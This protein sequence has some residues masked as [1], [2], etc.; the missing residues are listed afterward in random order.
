MWS[1]RW[2]RVILLLAIAG[3]VIYAGVNVTRRVGE[4]KKQLELL[5]EGQDEDSI[6]AGGGKSATS[7]LPSFKG[8][9]FTE[10]DEEGG[11]FTLSA[12][13]FQIRNKKIRFFRTAMFKEAVMENARVDFFRDNE[14]V[15]SISSRW[16]ILD[17][18]RMSASFTGSVSVRVGD[19]K[20]LECEKLVWS[21]KAGTIKVTGAFVYR[22]KGKV[23]RGAGLYSDIFMSKV[24]IIRR[25]EEE[26]GKR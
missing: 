14:L 1:P 3:F 17:L 6:Q 26:D 20:L 19:D 2:G 21:R 11:H 23:I 12:D 10:Y 22:E 24:N 7:G 9:S 18:V 15:S 13:N 4:G 25:R 5:S 8:F 16:A